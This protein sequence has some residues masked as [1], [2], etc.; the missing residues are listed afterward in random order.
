MGRFSLSLRRKKDKAGMGMSRDTTL[1]RSV[2]PAAPRAAA[3][4]AVES[5]LK[6]RNAMKLLS[7]QLCHRQLMTISTWAQLT[8]E[9]G[10]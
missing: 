4:S 3:R 5:M 8:L 9:L 7:A 10:S 6:E 2:T 1:A